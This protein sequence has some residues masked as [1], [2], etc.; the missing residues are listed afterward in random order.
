MTKGK[1]ITGWVMSEHGIPDSRWTVLKKV[2]S[3]DGKNSFYLCE[4]SCEQHTQKI[5]A[6]HSIVSGNSKSCGCLAREQASARMTTHGKSGTRLHHIWK[7]MHERCYCENHQQ[8]KDYGGR[9]I[10]ICDEWKNDFN[11][12]YEWALNNGYQDNLTIDRINNNGN[13]EPENC[14]WS[15]RKEQSNN[16]RTNRLLTYNNKTQTVSQ[17]AEEVGLNKHTLQTR[18]SRGWSVE[19]ALCRPVQH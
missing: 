2:E 12:F 3:L 6:R 17:W 10:I 7:S 15:T 18:I 8:F 4:C 14:K 19:D 11:S 16:Q 5:L 1:D 13:Y 9:G